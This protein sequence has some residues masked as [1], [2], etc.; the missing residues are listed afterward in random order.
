MARLRNGHD[1]G[2]VLPPLRSVNPNLQPKPPGRTMA[3]NTGRDGGRHVAFTRRKTAEV[4]S[5]LAEEHETPLERIHEASE[6]LR[7]EALWLRLQYEAEKAKGRRAD[8][9]RMV[10][11][12]K[13]WQ[14]FEEAHIYACS[15]MTN[16]C[17]PRLSAS[18]VKST[19][20][21]VI[22]TIILKNADGL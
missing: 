17:H 7:E 3:R 22:S 1:Q 12:R 5:K 10:K 14:D 11:L 13:M 15:T 21:D 16:Y 4:A 8:T 9:R 2:E 18:V 6:R 20:E 19:S